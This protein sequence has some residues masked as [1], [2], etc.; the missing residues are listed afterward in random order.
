M[1]RG[2]GSWEIT[3][4]TAKG[5]QESEPEG[6]PGYELSRPVASAVLPSAGLTAP[7]CLQTAP[8]TG[9]QVLKCGSLWR[10]FLI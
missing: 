3:P 4:L 1:V 8:S 7:K 9:D 10:V 2:E 5:K 6:G